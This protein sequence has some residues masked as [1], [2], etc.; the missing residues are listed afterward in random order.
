MVTDAGDQVQLDRLVI[1]FYADAT[2]KFAAK[3]AGIH[4]SVDTLVAELVRVRQKD[5]RAALRPALNGLEVAEFLGIAPGPQLGKAMKL[6]N[7]DENVRLN[8][9]EAF[10]LLR[11][12]FL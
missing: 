11:A 8:R 2:T 12:T 1:L 10:A 5:E 9:D 3:K 6:L 7:T 4:A